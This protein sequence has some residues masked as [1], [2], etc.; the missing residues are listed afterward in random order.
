MSW[1]EGI[2]DWGYHKAEKEEER[3]LKEERRNREMLAC[4]LLTGH[5]GFSVPEGRLLAGIKPLKDE[6]DELK[7]KKGEWEELTIVSMKLKEEALGAIETLKFNQMKAREREE[8]RKRR[9]EKLKN[10]Q[11]IYLRKKR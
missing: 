3:R 10:P 9:K 11:S 4:D 1:L 8:R 5:G 2:Y 6:I 7:A